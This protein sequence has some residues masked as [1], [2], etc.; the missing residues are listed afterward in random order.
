MSK[1]H[2]NT[3]DIVKVISGNHR[4]AQGKILRV[5]REKEQVFIEGVRMIK[6]HLGR[7]QDRPQGEIIEKEGPIHISNVK[8]IEAAT[9]NSSSNKNAKKAKAETADKPNKKTRAK[10]NT[11]E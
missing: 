2:V 10:K 3:G 1:T 11:E 4:G 7:S 5:L 8:L 6:K 9:A